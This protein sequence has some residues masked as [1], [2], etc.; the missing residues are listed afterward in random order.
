Q[1]AAG[2]A[3]DRDQDGDHEQQSEGDQRVAR[4]AHQEVIALDPEVARD[5]AH[6]AVPEREREHQRA[7]EPEQTDD[8]ALMARQPLL[9]RADR[10][11]S[12]LASA[13]H[14]PAKYSTADGRAI[15]AK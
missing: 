15:H 1:A 4:P 13:C 5:Y 12:A 9:A 6:R 7:E 11:A 14:R 10:C 8:L 3:P 2:R